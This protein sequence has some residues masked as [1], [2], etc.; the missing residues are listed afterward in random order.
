V[1]D[2]QERE[3]IQWVTA[4]TFVNFYT[5]RLL[6]HKQCVICN[7]IFL[8]YCSPSLE[9]YW[10][11]DLTFSVVKKR[12]RGAMPSKENF[13]F[14]QSRNIRYVLQ[15]HVFDLTPGEKALP[16]FAVVPS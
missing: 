2:I 11:C 8:S 15:H 4:V 9:I 10:F 12:T 7:C 6:R 5:S 13:D 1:C 14:R 16:S 3:D